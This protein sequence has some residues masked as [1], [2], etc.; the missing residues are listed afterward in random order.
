M[1]EHTSLQ[2][3]EENQQLRQSDT[4]PSVEN[5]IIENAEMIMINKEVGFAACTV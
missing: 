1:S 3:V 2:G 5:I 4:S